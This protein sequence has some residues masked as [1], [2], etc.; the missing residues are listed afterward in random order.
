MKSRLVVLVAA[1]LL[2]V[3]LLG[4]TV[5]AYDPTDP[6]R[7]GTTPTPMPTPTAVDPGG[8][9]PNISYYDEGSIVT[10]G[11]NPA[12]FTG[13]VARAVAQASGSSSQELARP[14]IWG[15]RAP[16]V[17]ATP[18]PS[19]VKESAITYCRTYTRYREARNVLGIRLWRFNHSVYW[20]YN[21]SR[22]TGTPVSWVWPSNVALGW[23]YAGQ[24]G[25]VQYW[26]SYP[27]KYYV[28]KQGKFKLCFS[29]CFQE[30]HPWVS[31]TVNQY[32]SD[33]G[34]TGG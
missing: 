30:V 14:T 21:S 6:I 2:G 26:Q 5:V 15:R 23:Q 27:Y 10:E 33:T 3:V 1:V 19:Q 34:Y 9:D 32:G 18:T 24:I 28:W 16:A 8:D 13:D 20:C 29:W 12:G 17:K 4:R 7:G 25:A 11:F 22:I 31:H